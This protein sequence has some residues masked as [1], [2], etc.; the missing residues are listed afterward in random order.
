[1]MRLSYFRLTIGQSVLVAG[2]YGSNLMRLLRSLWV[3]IVEMSQRPRLNYLWMKWL[4]VRRFTLGD[5]DLREG[6]NARRSKV[7]AKRSTRFAKKCTYNR[8]AGDQIPYSHVQKAAHHGNR[9][10][11]SA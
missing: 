11:E 8:G 5:P 1:M 2:I 4:Q 3:W 10:E 7:D 6:S 9:G